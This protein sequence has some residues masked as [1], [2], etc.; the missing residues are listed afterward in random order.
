MK[1]TIIQLWQGNIEDISHSGINSTELRH[2][3]TLRQNNFERLSAELSDNQK[4]LLEKYRDTFD[5]YML[6]YTE[7]SFCDGFCFGAKLIAEA[8]IE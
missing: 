1:S 5:E 7:Q 2:L 6:V 8:L 4:A 3:E